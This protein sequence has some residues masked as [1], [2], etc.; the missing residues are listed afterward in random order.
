MSHLD[1]SSKILTVEIW[2]FVL[3]IF[4]LIIVELVM[5]KYNAEVN[6]EL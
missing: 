1:T 6:L 4:I 2:G 3:A 5:G